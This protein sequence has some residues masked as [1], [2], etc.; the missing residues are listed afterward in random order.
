MGLMLGGPYFPITRGTIIEHTKVNLED[1]ERSASADSD[2]GSY[3][4]V[5]QIGATVREPVEQGTDETPLIEGERTSPSNASGENLECLAE[6]VGTLGPRNT[7]KNRCGAAKRRARKARLR[8]A[9]SG[10][11]AMPELGLLQAARH[12]P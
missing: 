4:E 6:K 12:E 11:L 1:L 10:T 5:P 9:P 2:K 8:R 3:T 7:S